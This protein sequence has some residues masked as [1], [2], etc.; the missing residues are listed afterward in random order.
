MKAIKSVVRNMSVAQRAE[1]KK[2]I[3]VIKNSEYKGT[4]I[5]LELEAELGRDYS[6]DDT[7]S[8]CDDDGYYYCDDCND[9]SVE[10]ENCNG[11]GEITDPANHHLDIDCPECDEGYVTCDNCD[12]VARTDCGSCDGSGEAGDGWT[13]DACSEFILNHI[14]AVT[15]EA[16]TYSCFYNDGSVDSEFTFTLPIDKAHHAIYVIEA[17]NL[18]AKEIDGCFETNGAGMHIAILNNP[19]GGYP[20]GNRLD[21]TKANNFARSMTP[22]LPALY[23]LASATH[24]SRGL[25]YRKPRVTLYD[26][27]GCISGS[28]NVFEYRI[29]ETCYERPLAVIDYIIVIANTLKYYTNNY[30]DTSLKIGE[31]GIKNGNGLDRFYYT[32]KHLK[33]LERG[34]EMLR[35]QYKSFQT[36][37]KERNFTIDVNKLKESEKQR[38]EEWKQEFGQVKTRRAY[39]RLRIYHDYLSRGYRA[40]AEG[41][42]IDPQQ[43]AKEMLKVTMNDRYSNL[44]GSAREYVQRKS[45]EFLTESVDYTIKV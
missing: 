20:Y 14:P 25:S 41:Q 36:L 31:L 27:Y 21:E 3:E 29:F 11:T 23:F 39:E 32:S 10:C 43:Y 15:R 45:R 17:F 5:K 44:K 13:N 28:H 37:K 12:G 9:G 7:C 16:L 34:V 18:L 26:K 22:L 6:E 24:D 42:D 35:P 19:N 1:L 40:K 38:V 4:H 30:I 8:D 33:A 2:S